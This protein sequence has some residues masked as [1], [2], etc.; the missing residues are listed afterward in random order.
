MT[1]DGF[2]WKKA[3]AEAIK[4]KIRRAITMASK[5]DSNPDFAIAHP[6]WI[7][8]AQTKNYT[9]LKIKVTQLIE[10]QQQ[11]SLARRLKLAKSEAT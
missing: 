10:K 9:D 7:K 2:S 1:A 4:T 11:R 6:D 8:Q 3:Q 5:K